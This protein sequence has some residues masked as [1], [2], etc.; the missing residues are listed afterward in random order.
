MCKTGLGDKTLV[1]NMNMNNPIK[2]EAMGTQSL[3]LCLLLASPLAFSEGSPSFGG[4]D[5][6]ERILETDRTEKGGFIETEVFTPLEQ[7]QGRMKED[8]GFSLGMDYSAVTVNA[9]ESLP[10]TDDSASGGMFRIFGSWNLTG[11]G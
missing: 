11:D 7:W 2:I 3:L 5:S 1:M 6:V 9:S 8:H 4:P 10:G